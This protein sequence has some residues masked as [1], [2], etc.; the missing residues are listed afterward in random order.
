M[1]LTRQEVEVLGLS[2]LPDVSARTLRSELETRDGFDWA[3]ARLMWLWKWAK[4]DRAYGIEAAKD[5]RDMAAAK[6]SAI[7]RKLRE[8]AFT[9]EGIPIFRAN[10]VLDTGV[11]RYPVL[12]FGVPDSDR[13]YGSTYLSRHPEMQEG[14]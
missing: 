12:C 5:H 10:R 3:A 8:A 4:E 7:E 6:L 14:A 2:F 9:E 1:P 11:W 13:I